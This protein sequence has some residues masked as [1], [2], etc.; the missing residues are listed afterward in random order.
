[1]APVVDCFA[2]SCLTNGE[3]GPGTAGGGAEEDGGML[4]GGGEEVG[5][6][7]EIAVNN[8][9]AWVCSET[10]PGAPGV[11]KAVVAVDE[12]TEIVDPCE[13][14]TLVDGFEEGAGWQ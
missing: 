7:G 6:D 11:N 2:V 10:E 12:D 13:E 5:L 9:T 1:M 3:A 4:S 8:E 14:G